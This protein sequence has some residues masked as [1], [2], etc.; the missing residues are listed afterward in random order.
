MLLR[1]LDFGREER[2]LQQFAANFARDATVRFPAPIAELCTSRVLTMELLDGVKLS[3]P[4]RLVELGHDLEEL[5]RRGAGVFLE[6]IFR[7]GFYHADPHPG[8]LLVL[9]GGVIGM[10]DC[11]MT[12]RLDDGMR[13]DIEEML[14]AI[15]SND[16]GR[17]TSLVMRLGSVPSDV[18]PAALGTDLAEFLSYHTGVALRQLD[19][20]KVLTEFAEIVRRHRI[21]L[22]GGIALLLRVLVL[23]EGTSRLLN[24]CFKLTELMQPYEQR[25]LWRRLSPARRL[26]KLRRLYHEWQYVGE[27]LP[28][29]IVDVLRQVQ[30]GSFTVHLEHEHLEPAVN[31]L[32]FGMLTSALFLGSALLWSH[33]IP[34]LL[35]GASVMGVVGCTISA[36][37]GLRL[38]WAINRSGHLDR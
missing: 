28:R 21:V 11:G 22:P 36:V 24:P 18:D 17:L 1:E 4:Q 16:A 14:V 6:M 26:Q 8:N 25:L 29:G 35:G 30:R 9:P 3:E 5:A 27:V 20:G 19:L 15:V 34:P 23:L 33:Q 37:L 31:R 2:N 10:L 7:D 13:E 12:G 38:L 32:V